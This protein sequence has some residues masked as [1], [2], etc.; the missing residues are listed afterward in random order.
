MRIKM[1][2]S[3][4]VLL[5][6]ISAT[7][8]NGCSVFTIGEE[9]PECMVDVNLGVACVSAREVWAATDTYDNLTG[10]T[11][12]EVRQEA[13][14][15][16]PSKTGSENTAQ[17]RDLYK[18]DEVPT[19]NSNQPASVEERS[20][21]YSRYQEERLHLPSPDPLA[22][23]E[24]P[25]ILRVTI[26]PFIDKSDRLN[27]P[28]QIFAEVEKR[29]WT[30]GTEAYKN[31]NRITPTSIRSTSRTVT[32]TGMDA[33]IDNGG[34]GVKSRPKA[35]D[36]DLEGIIPKGSPTIRGN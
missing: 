34:M 5:S 12:S 13:A 35:K 7:M 28:P 33:P 31:T 32:R 22:I 15:N 25:G 6:L 9:P 8:L 11:A 17:Q 19:R 36:F 16:D 4:I 30:I 20:A 21:A 23:R 10:M 18:Y 2:K 27:M 24:T 29:T 26:S 1:K 3:K 14:K